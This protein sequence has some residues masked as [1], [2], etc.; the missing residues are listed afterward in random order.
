MM[1]LRSAMSTTRR[2]GYFFALLNG[3]NGACPWA[4]KFT[5]FAEL[6]M[7]Y[8]LTAPSRYAGFKASPRV[9]TRVRFNRSGSTRRF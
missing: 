4:G 5:S 2:P 9:S 8:D 6:I 7:A 1:E 3:E